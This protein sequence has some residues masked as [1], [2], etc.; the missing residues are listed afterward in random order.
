MNLSFTLAQ[1]DDF[2]EL[3]EAIRLLQDREYFDLKAYESFHEDLLNCKYSKRDFW[4]CK[5]GENLCGYIFVNYFSMPCYIGYGVEMQEVVVISKYQRQGIG[6]KFI[7]FLIEHYRQDDKC[8]K[9]II[10]TDDLNGSG[11]LYSDI[12]YSTSIKTYQL[13]LNKV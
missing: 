12:L 3:F 9:I 10:K 5:V 2:K 8:R 7:K 11:R 4:V 6:R 13:Y 1:K